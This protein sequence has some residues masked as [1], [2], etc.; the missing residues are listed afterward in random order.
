MFLRFSR[1][2]AILVSLG[3]VFILAP[4][5]ASFRLCISIGCKAKLPALI[6]DGHLRGSYSVGHFC[7]ANLKCDKFFF[8]P[9]NKFDVFL[10]NV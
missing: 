2:F 4:I 8:W 1:L 5:M 10:N 9:L 7:S 3:I 6:Y